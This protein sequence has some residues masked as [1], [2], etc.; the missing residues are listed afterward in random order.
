MSLALAVAEILK[1]NPKFW[2]APLAQS[3]THFSSGCD[4]VMVL[5]KP[6]LYTKFEVAS[7]IHCRN[8]KEEPQN[9]TE[10]P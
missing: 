9:V 1:G 3:Q 2:D 5:S 10:L 7:F 6:K 4:F 8:I